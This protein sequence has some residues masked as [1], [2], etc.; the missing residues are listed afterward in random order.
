M[1]AT[2]GTTYNMLGSRL[3]SVA[4][5][6]ENLR[7]IGATGK[8]LQVASDD[9]AAVR[10]VLNTRKQ[11]SNI[12][13]YVETM[14]N[15]SDIMGAT[16]GNLEHVENIMQRAE[17]IMVNAINGSLNDEDRETL[18][19]ELDQLT[20]ELLDAANAN[21]DGKY[22]FAGY[23]EDTKPFV[24]N[25]AY[26][27]A[28]Y[29]P[30]DHRTW[31]VLYN[32]DDNATE[33]EIATN[34]RLEVNLTGNRLFL[35]TS[36][37]RQG[38]YDAT[39]PD[40]NNDPNAIE[41]GMYNLFTELTQAAEAIRADN[42]TEMQT[43]LDDLQG[44]AEQSRRL[45]SQLGNRAARVESAMVYQENVKVDLQQILSRYEDAD[46]IEVFNDI[47]QQET[48]FQAALS[49]TGKVSA[50]SILDYI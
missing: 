10:P 26:D 47:V 20:D 6:L 31:P 14:G 19:N 3:N 25:T 39:D 48:A 34:E 30:N 11:I 28:L 37:W 15:A 16:D 36:V 23:Q 38:P 17:E 21:I 46:A 45:R 22:I 9:P 12:D 4:L 42:D 49:I 50:L 2:Q 43:A 1:K 8:K 24:Y 18:A 41:S 13:R 33:L 32:G 35:G 5:E 40:P 27:P 29:D 44:A 7:S